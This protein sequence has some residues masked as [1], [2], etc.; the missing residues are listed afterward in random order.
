[1]SGLLHPL[2]GIDHLLAAAAI[3]VWAGRLGGWARAALPAV[4][5]GVGALAGLA[6]AAIAPVSVLEPIVL[7]S[8]V[9]LVAFA[10]FG[11]R[12]PVGCSLALAAAFAAPH[13]Y[14]HM[15]AA[16]GGALGAYGLGVAVTTLAVILAGLG[17]QALLSPRSPSRLAA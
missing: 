2:T 11:A 5:V 6:A 3:G 10:A 8:T 14:A 9:A 13:G 12:A 4:F 1:M 16:D 15:A 7:G 17:A